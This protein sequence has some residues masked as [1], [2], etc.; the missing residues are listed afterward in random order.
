MR[1]FE[2]FDATPVKLINEGGNLELPG[3]HVADSINLKVHDRSFIV[4]VL[5]KLLNNINAA[6]AK[7]YNKPLWSSTL[8]KSGKFLS[9]SSL[10]FFNTNIPDNE[11]VKVKPKVGDIDTQVN[12]ADEEKLEKFLEKIQG[13]KLGNAKFLGFKRGNEQFSSLWELSTPPLK[14]QIDLEFVSYERGKPTSWAQF[15]H[16]SSWDDIQAGIKGVFH[17]YVIQSFSS[18]TKQD[19]LLRKMVGRGKARTLQD[20]PATDNMV[21]FAVSSKEGGG[22]RQKYEPVIDPVTKKPLI[23]DGLPVLTARPTEGYDQ[24]LAGIFS[25]LFGK[26][27]SHAL[28]EKLSEKFWSFKGL[29]EVMNLL[30]DNNEKQ[31]VVDSFTDKLFGKGAQGLYK[32]DPDRDIKEKIV[33]LRVML[34]TLD[35]TEP[36]DL[37]QKVKDYKASY[38]VL[39]EADAPNY[40]RQGIKH[41]YNPGSSTEMKDADFLEL[42]NEI[43]ANGGNL[44]GFPIS[45]KVDGAGIRFGKD[46]NGRAFLMTSRVIKPL[47]AEN[48]GDFEKYGK[49]VGQ[50]DEQLARTRNYDRALDTIVNSDWIQKLPKDTIVQAEML[51]NPM[52]EKTANGLKFVNISY[53]PKKLGS[54]MTLVPI[55]FR[56]YST[57]D[58]LPNA[59]EIKDML[60]KSSTSAIKFVNS[61]LKQAKIDVSKIIDPVVKM[62]T[63]LR[64]A[65]GS[66]KKDDPLKAK[67][68][69]ILTQVR[70]A[71]S[72]AIIHNP[73]LV[74]KEQLGKNLEGIVIKMPSGML[75]KVT[76][77]DMQDIMAAKKAAAPRTG[78][79]RIKPAVVTVGSF[80][81]HIGHQHLVNLVLQKAKKV[82]GDPYV[83]ISPKVGPDDPFPPQVKLET[84][85]K[86]YPEH[87]S[88][89]QIIAAPDGSPS[90]PMKK[91][92]KDLVLPKT[93]PYNKIILMV[94]EDR[95]DSFKT[96]IETLEKRMKDP[97]A[98]AKFGG[99]QDQVSYEVIGIPRSKE[100]GGTDMSFTELRNV[101]KN[102]NATDGQKL[103]VWEKG[104]DVKKLGVPY[105]KH[106]MA[107][108]E[109]NMGITK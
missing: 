24:S 58:V 19:F 15:S 62:G 72:D 79:N 31:R 105:I 4:P 35:M 60:L 78:S 88:M 33:A 50:T 37:K 89:F 106:L 7:A 43:H 76:S 57:G 13:K 96:W 30:L 66:R 56:R 97:A 8:L 86:L 11:F 18:L 52:A 38:K 84:W 54:T 82:G 93:S 109:K 94:G 80:V 48:V 85:K 27:L 107:I 67:A 40:A 99:T 103:A 100:N 3:G 20:V 9:G 51:Y 14:I 101:L 73:N 61:D 6:Y 74:G 59:N 12:K 104:F 44:D 5:E 45:L 63:E 102:P 69:D 83:Y 46:E 36:S 2:V 65:L 64:T 34:E 47:Y 39:D 53:D 68:K 98:L 92:E 41:I 10:H 91:I 29:L 49:S 90:T 71:L 87:A 25:K 1:L 23:K 21:S 77:S 75:V 26:K 16:S 32:G 108:A 81:G 22:L 55:S 42:V 95:Y 70:K 28:F 17:K